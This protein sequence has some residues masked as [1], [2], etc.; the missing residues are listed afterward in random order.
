MPIAVT[1]PECNANY[2][3]ADE[4]AGKA[5]KCK[6]CGARVA[7]PAAAA[8]DDLSALGAG[9]ATNGEK[10][11][12]EGGKPKK[13][14]NT[15]LIIAIAAGL[16]AFCCVCVPGGSFATYWFGFRNT[17]PQVQMKGGNIVVKDG[18]NIDP[19]AIEEQMKKALEGALKKDAFKSNVNK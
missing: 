3:V 15:T 9:S 16:V 5:I 11:G 1:C 18:K 4:A 19:K 17:T 2:R 13:K 14:S 10:E 8:D 12:A 6:K 7:V